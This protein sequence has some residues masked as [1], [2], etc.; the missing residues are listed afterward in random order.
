MASVC[1]NLI[2]LAEVPALMAVTNLISGY[3]FGRLFSTA[4]KK[5]AAVIAGVNAIVFLGMISI[6][7]ICKLSEKKKE[8][9]FYLNFFIIIPL[10]VGATLYKTNLIAGK[11]KPILGAT[12]S[13]ITNLFTIIL[14]IK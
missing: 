12:I 8:R 5:C 4:P 14:L 10:A 11:I 2:L 3:A 9:L 6:F 13:L 1:K 7:S